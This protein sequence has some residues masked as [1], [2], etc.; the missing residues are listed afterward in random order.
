[1]KNISL[2]DEELH[3]FI[4]GELDDAS[5]RSV[6]A[7]V[8]A[9]AELTA[10][11]DHY[12]ADKALIAGI[13]GP[14]IDRP[15]PLAMMRPLGREKS[16][17]RVRIIA[18]ITSAAAAIAAMIVVAWFGYPMINGAVTDP[19]VAEAVAVR[20]GKVQA[21]REIDSSQVMTSDARNRLAETILAVP[22]RVPN[23]EKSGY[24]LASI[25]VYPDHGNRHSLQLSYRGRNGAL[26]T[27]YLRP[28]AGADR[29]ALSR[30]GEM[31]V[32]V[33]QNDKMS[34]VMLGEISAREMLR[35]ATSTY[36]DLDF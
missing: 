25:A 9:S 19:L 20:Q 13:Y 5:A 11:V 26:F 2:T 10:L 27:M 32:C 34:V 18:R 3:A 22:V 35:V 28:I 7:A 14:L 23:L 31:Q 21:D 12:R 6:A 30:R 29:F 36:A 15:V 16:T 4:D 24:V 8:A 17:A 33:W 1:M